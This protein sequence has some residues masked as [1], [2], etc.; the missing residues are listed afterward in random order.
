MR[1]TALVTGAG[2][3]IGRAIAAALADDGYA[4]AIHYNT[5]QD[6][7][8]SLAEEIATRGGTAV[9]IG[10]D[11]AERGAAGDVAKTRFG[12]VGGD[13][14]GDDPVLLREAHSLGDGGVKGGDVGDDMV[15]WHHEQQRVGVSPCD[16]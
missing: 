5:S 1:K 6:E 11:L 3:R 15:A 4:V 2:Q 8:E 13:A 10:F 14:E 12:A 9:P 7:A 16:G